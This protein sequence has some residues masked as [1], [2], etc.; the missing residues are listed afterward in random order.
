MFC[1]NCGTSLS[2]TAEFCSNCGY[3]TKS[4]QA[5]PAKSYGQPYSQPYYQ[6]AMKSEVLSIILAFIIPGAGHLYL[7]RLKRGLIILVAY[8]GLAVISMGVLFNVFPGLFVADPADIVFD[9]GS[10]TVLAILSIISLVIW[11]VQLIDAYNL[12][13]QYNESVRRTGQAPW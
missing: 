7:G 13:K 2:D 3:N 10:L 12:T 9:T 4:G 1:P 11:I 8:F 6:T 5:P